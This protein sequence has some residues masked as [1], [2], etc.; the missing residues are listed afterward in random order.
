MMM[1]V[2]QLCSSLLFTAFLFVVSALA[3]TPDC[4]ITPVNS[5]CY[6]NSYMKNALNGDSLPTYV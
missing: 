3:G 6:I 4:N 1:S 5:F 2:G